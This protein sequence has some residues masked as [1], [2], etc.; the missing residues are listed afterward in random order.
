MALKETPDG[1]V[2]PLLSLSVG[3][4][5]PVAATVKLPAEPAVKVALLPLVKVGASLTV[6][7]KVWVASGEVPLLAV[8]CRAWVP[9]VPAADVPLSTP[10][11]GLKETPAG[12]LSPLLS[13]SAGAGG[14]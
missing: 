14:P 10:V 7:V 8:K 5:K 1:R 13:L 12:R 4:G 9:P 3:A 6:R 2:S 11:A